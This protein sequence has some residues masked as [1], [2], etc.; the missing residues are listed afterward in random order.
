M[1][2]LIINKLSYALIKYILNVRYFNFTMAY[3]NGP[4]DK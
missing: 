1:R 2:K 4:K 3:H